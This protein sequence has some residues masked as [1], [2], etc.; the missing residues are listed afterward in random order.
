MRVGSLFSGAGGFDLAA[1]RVGMEV[2][3]QSETDKYADWAP[4][5]LQAGTHSL[6]G[7]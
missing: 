1:E 3:W 6:C 7:G 5:H 4:L 2:A